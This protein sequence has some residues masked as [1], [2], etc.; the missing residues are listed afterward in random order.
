MRKL[1]SLVIVI[2]AV[3][4]VQEKRVIAPIDSSV[5][6][7]VCY[8]NLGGTT[9][10]AHMIV[11]VSSRIS[12]GDSCEGFHSR[13]YLSNGDFVPVRATRA[14]VMIELE[15]CKRKLKGI[16]KLEKVGDESPVLK[17]ANEP[18][19]WDGRVTDAKND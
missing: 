15:K 3:G 8:I 11:S 10:A 9:I 14:R 13:I 4:C 19:N 16:S 18:G 6:K 2:L 17:K 7:D 1:L 5:M 12:G